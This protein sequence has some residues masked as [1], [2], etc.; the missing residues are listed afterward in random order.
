LTPWRQV[1]IDPLPMVLVII[2]QWWWPRQ[3]CGQGLGL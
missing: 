1:K 2:P 3:V